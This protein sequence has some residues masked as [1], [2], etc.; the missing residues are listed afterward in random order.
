VSHFHWDHLLGLPFFHPIHLPD[1][2]LHLYSAFPR[3]NLERHIRA[4]FDGTYSPLR[5]IDNLKASINFHEI[6]AAGLEIAGARVRLC[7]VHHTEPCFA[8]R[9][10][11]G[12]SSLAYVTD[13]EAGPSDTNRCVVD[14]AQGVD[15]LLH[16]AQF[17]REEYAIRAG[18]GHS[19]IEAALENGR[20]A[21]V[22]QLLLTHHDPAHT[23]TFLRDYLA[24]H[25]SATEV[26]RV[27][28]AAEG[29]EIDV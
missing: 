26:P 10:E 21:G 9:I 8:V 7:P 22:K 25:L 5:D 14:F 3:A 28:L 20:Q 24:T 15:L 16:D 4:L 12:A 17:T 1:T 29:G 27:N 23:D 19:S 11:H 13:H 2:T 18:W 6:P